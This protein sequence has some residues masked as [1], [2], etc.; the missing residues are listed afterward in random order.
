MNSKVIR[1]MR[2]SIPTG[3]I[4]HIVIQQGQSQVINRLNHSFATS[5][6]FFKY[7]MQDENWKVTKIRTILDPNHPGES[8]TEIIIDKL[9]E[10][11]NES[12]K[13][14][15]VKDVSIV[16][17]D[18][19]LSEISFPKYD[20]DN[21]D[22]YDEFVKRLIELWPEVKRQCADYLDIPTFLEAEEVFACEINKN[23]NEIV[24]FCYENFP[25]LD[26]DFSYKV[27]GNR[28]EIKSTYSFE[29]LLPDYQHRFWE[30]LIIANDTIVDDQSSE[31]SFVKTRGL[32]NV[33][34]EVVIASDDGNKS[35]LLLVKNMG[36]P[37]AAYNVYRNGEI[38]DEEESHRLPFPYQ[39]SVDAFIFRIK[40][41]LENSNSPDIKEKKRK[42][43]EHIKYRN[44]CFKTIKDDHPNFTQAQ[45]AM[46]YNDQLLKRMNSNDVS[47][48]DRWVSENDVRKAFKENDWIWTR[49]VRTR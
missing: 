25:Q 27:F 16:S 39:D 17:L 4:L 46:E 10:S 49:G 26:D 30:F 37:V 6:L 34:A 42:R 1:V 35:I 48:S 12:P 20:V 18:E 33:A 2:P 7:G 32:R 47:E 28:L 5:P 15:V 43:A 21:K 44:E 31:A 23:P 3:Y 9:L 14:D 11:G 41:L 29:D 24:R 38:V 22:F 40:N 8:S 13:I 19:K 45:V 36:L